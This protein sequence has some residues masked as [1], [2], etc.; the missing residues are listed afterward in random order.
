MVKNYNYS[1]NESGYK[2]TLKCIHHHLWDS[3]KLIDFSQDYESHGLYFI[4]AN[5]LPSAELCHITASGFKSL[6]VI[7]FAQ[8]Y[9]EVVWL[10]LKHLQKIPLNLSATLKC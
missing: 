5:T 9:A 4:L 1:L 10:C 2:C 8:L 6:A 3:D 7:L